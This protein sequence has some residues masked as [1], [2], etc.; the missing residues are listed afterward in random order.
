MQSIQKNSQTRISRKAL[1]KKSN[2]RCKK[3]GRA[4]S[5]IKTCTIIQAQEYIEIVDPQ[6]RTEN[7]ETD[8]TALDIWDTVRVSW[9]ETDFLISNI[10][11]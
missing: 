4:D 2:E 10:C 7:P 6:Q 5:I 11:K 9:R 3:R 8:P 1:K